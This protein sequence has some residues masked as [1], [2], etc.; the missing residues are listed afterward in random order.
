MKKE[1][2]QHK[3]GLCPVCG[4]EW[5]VYD[6]EPFYYDNIQKWN[7]E[8]ADCH[9]YGYEEHQL[10]FLGTLISKP[11]CDEYYDEGCEVEVKPIAKKK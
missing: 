6:D 9:S 11:A 7:F 5:L 8:C 1:I 3:A 4:S 10:V 2:K